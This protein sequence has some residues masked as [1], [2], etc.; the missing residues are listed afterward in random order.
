MASSAA[1]AP[2]CR[3]AFRSCPTPPSLEEPLDVPFLWPACSRAD[4]LQLLHSVRQRCCCL[5][6]M[7]R[8]ALSGRPQE[9]W[10]SGS[11]ASRALGCSGRE[12]RAMVTSHTAHLYVTSSLMRVHPLFN[13]EIEKTSRPLILPPLFITLTHCDEGLQCAASGGPGG[14]DRGLFS[15]HAL[16]GTSGEAEKTPGPAAAPG[17]LRPARRG[18]VKSRAPAAWPVS[19]LSGDSCLRA[20]VRHVSTFCCRSLGHGHQG[21]YG[22]Q[23]TLAAAAATCACGFGHK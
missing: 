18:T 5:Q 16:G 4:A 21:T 19:S 3:P 17:R 6:R 20:F 13:Q 23:R 7:A 2:S 1:T 15:F 10:A 12:A 9:C 8:L 14:P 22:T 11:S